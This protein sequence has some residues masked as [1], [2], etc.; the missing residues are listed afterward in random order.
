MSV[1]ERLE[2]C[3]WGKCGARI[4]RGDLW[5]GHHTHAY[6]ALASREDWEYAGKVLETWVAFARE[7]GGSEALIEATED[8]LDRAAM[9]VKFYAAELESYGGMPPSKG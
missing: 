3:A 1:E 5:C 8:A 9:E 2:R 6:D 7:F 4:K